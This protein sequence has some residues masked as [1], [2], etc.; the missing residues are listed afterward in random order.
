MSEHTE[1]L[2]SI[3][4]RGGG[5]AIYGLYTVGMCLGEEYGFQAIYSSIGYINQSVWV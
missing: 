3:P 2:H 5:T 1:R 4:G